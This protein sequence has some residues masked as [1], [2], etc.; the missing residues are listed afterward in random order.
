M[1]RGVST[2]ELLIVM[3]VGGVVA[4]AIGNLLRRQQRFFTNAAAVVEQRVSLRD[5]TGIL[6][7]EIRGLSPAG[8]DVLTF[9]DSAL[10]MRA[11]IGAAI[12]CDTVAGGGAI[13]LAPAR[14]GA[15]TLAAFATAPQPGDVALVFD[16]GVPS[17]TGGWTALDITSA[18]PRLDVCARSPLI[19]ATSDARAAR[20]QLRFTTGSRVP[21]S[22]RPGAFVRVL[23][24][25]RYRFYRASTSQWFLG[26]SEWEGVAFGAVQ[27]VS[28]P[29]AAYSRRSGSGLL[30]R[31]FDDAG[32][33]VV[34]PTDAARIAR[35]EIVVRGAPGAGLSDVSR[36]YTDSETVS[37][38]VRNR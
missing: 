24:R 12:A 20:L 32:G 9:S 14:A 4:A 28:G 36:G 26:Y 13:D 16:S 8:G 35:V 5:A 2:I 22:V 23:R 31:Y 6:P 33:E 34:S 17:D 30:L 19:D 37:V 10:E 27:P 3:V 18:T 25:V 38:G 29:Y 7:G 21:P 1:R 11:T 15:R